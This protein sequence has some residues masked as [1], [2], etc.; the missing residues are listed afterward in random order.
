M[1]KWPLLVC[2]ILILFSSATAI[3]IAPAIMSIT[4]Q[5]GE[6]QTIT[7]YAV[8]NGNSE[9]EAEAYVDTQILQNIKILDSPTFKIPPNTLKPFTIS[10]VTPKNLPAGSYDVAVGIR[11]VSGGTSEGLSAK[12]AAQSAL[13]LE[14]P[15]GALKLV[16]SMATTNLS[17]PGM[18]AY[19]YIKAENPM[20][21]AIGPV[22]G[23]LVVSDSNG[24]EVYRTDLQTITSVQPKNSARVTATWSKTEMGRYTAV[25]T[26]NYA[27]Q[28][29]SASAAVQVGKPSVEVLGINVTQQS[30]FATILTTV[31][32]KWAEPMQVHAE[33]IGY[34]K[35][36]LV[37]SGTSN[38]VKL[39]PGQSTEL[40]TV[41]DIKTWKIE[42]LDFDVIVFFDGHTTQQSITAEGYFPEQYQGLPMGAAIG[43]KLNLEFKPTYLIAIL[44]IIIAFILY[45]FYNE[46]DRKFGR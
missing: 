40:K 18:P 30:G 25:A 36:T 26:F 9:I 5:P 33:V 6:K 35:G 34:Y 38:T 44:L 43:S 46:E 28:T 42:D 21:A 37:G 1:S 11:E 31:S 27:G 12:V 22:Q 17:V 32:N 10:F 4:L 23:N 8:N 29:D 2:C 14:N 19:F 3:G 20:D 16:F 39:E 15:N 45:K 24:K 7:Y 13:H 41:V